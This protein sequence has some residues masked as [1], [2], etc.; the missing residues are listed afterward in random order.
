MY[1]Y[2][3]YS[4]AKESKLQMGASHCVIAE[5]QTKP[6]K[7]NQVLLTSEP[8]VITPLLKG[9]FF[10]KMNNNKPLLYFY[11]K[12]LESRYCEIQ[13]KLAENGSYWNLMMLQ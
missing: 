11:L 3:V 6:L 13:S 5:N 4:K 8:S 10:V 1:G 12:C 2:F 7:S 9:I